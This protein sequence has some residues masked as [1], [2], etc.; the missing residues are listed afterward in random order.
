MLQHNYNTEKLN[1]LRKEAT[2]ARLAKEANPQMLRK[3]VAKLFSQI[4]SFFDKMDNEPKGP[5]NKKATA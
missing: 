3:A 5:F 4:T 2:N 1:R